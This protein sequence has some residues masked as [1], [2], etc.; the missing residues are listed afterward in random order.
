MAK[1]IKHSTQ[2]ILGFQAAHITDN[3]HILLPD[4]NCRLEMKTGDV[5]KSTISL[6]PCFCQIYKYT[7][8]LLYPQLFF[9]S[10]EAVKHTGSR[11][12]LPPFSP[13]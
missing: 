5:S 11:D 12:E 1:C 3:C 10:W 2:T 6:Y 13:L 9:F 8:I 4:S 7:W